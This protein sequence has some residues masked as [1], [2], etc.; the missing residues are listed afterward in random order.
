MTTRAPLDRDELRRRLVDTG[1]Y[2]RLTVVDSTGSTNAD[3]LQAA[4]DGAPTFTAELAEFQDSGRGRRGRAWV[5]PR[6]S[7]VTFSIL[8]RP[9]TLD[10]FGSLSL[11][12]GLALVDAL[13]PLL[14]ERVALKWPN[15]VLVSG[16]KICGIL[17]EAQAL[18]TNHPEVV[19]GCGLNH[20]LTREEL[21]VDN[22]TSLALEGIDVDRTE[23]SIAVL[24]AMRT[25]LGAW[26]RGDIHM[27]D[28]R[29]VCSTIGLDV[30]VMRPGT[31]DLLGR[32]ID[33]TDEGF[34]VVRDE[35]GERHEL[36][37]G[38]VHHVRPLE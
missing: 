32:A 27:D 12:A 20:S 6:S 4:A 36:S 19:L 31:D 14:H 9:R 35:R 37:A 11:M 16:N 2:E 34:L 28:Y 3:L 23:L 29:A 33:V 15:D 1:L 30:R 24:T 8:V 7:Q 26:S 22:A 13:K 21:P 25:R 10:H 17:G 18:A 38:E 5:T